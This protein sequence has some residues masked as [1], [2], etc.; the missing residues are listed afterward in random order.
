MVSHRP[1]R[2]GCHTLCGNGYIMALIYHMI[3]LDQV[4]KG[5]SDFMGSSPLSLVTIL[6]NLVVMQTRTQRIFLPKEEGK[7]KAREHF[8]HATKI[9]LNRGHIF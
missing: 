6:P 5:S 7:M 1:A 9:C 4:I 3:M 2:F 8:R